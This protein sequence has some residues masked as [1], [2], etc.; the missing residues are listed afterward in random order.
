M[1]GNAV[2]SPV[3]RFVLDSVFEYQSVSV[4]RTAY[5]QIGESGVYESGAVWEVGLDQPPLATNL[6]DVVDRSNTAPMS[7]RAASGLLT[8]LRRSG[9][10]CPDALLRL[11]E[12][13]AGMGIEGDEDEDTQT[14]VDAPVSKDEAKPDEVESGQLCFF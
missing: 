14:D 9:K 13:V 2:A 6:R 5:A 10:P 7:S 3:G 1:A 11:L 8:R 4:V 12:G